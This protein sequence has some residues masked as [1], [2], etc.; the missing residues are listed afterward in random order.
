LQLL[1]L[2]LIIKEYIYIYIYII[3]SLAIL[4][5][6]DD[7][8]LA[9]KLNQKTKIGGLI[10][11]LTDRIFVLIVFIFFAYQLKIGLIYILLFFARDLLTFLGTILLIRLKVKIE[12]K[13]KSWGKV[14]TSLQFLAI[15]TLVGKSLILTRT[16]IILI[17]VFTLFAIVQYLKEIKNA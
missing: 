12:I 13:A 4:S 2:I 17:S 6:Y 9:R 7:G 16:I 3:T 14:I 11:P 8:F 5:D 15:L 1:S 10:D